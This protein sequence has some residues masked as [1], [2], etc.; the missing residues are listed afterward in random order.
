M[1]MNEKYEYLFYMYIYRKLNLEDV[2]NKLE[3]ENIKKCDNKN[4]SKY[5]TLLNSGDID[6]FTDDELRMFNYY[7]NLKIDE[8]LS[9]S[10]KYKEV[11]NFI[12]STYQKYFFSNLEEK[13][14]YYGTSTFEYMAP[15]DAITLGFY[16]KQ[17]DF[18]I[19]DIDS[20]CLE[21][22]EK[23]CDIINYIQNDLAKKHNL[24]IAVIKYNEVALSQPY[25][26]I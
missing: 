7:F 19:E 13:Y 18:G 12:E 3:K 23:I 6:A 17:F 9:D 10:D 11:I 4:I 26:R 14:I 25:I 8:I 21:I 16:Y 5:F 1:N 24:K 15:S 2:E 22:D 20:Y